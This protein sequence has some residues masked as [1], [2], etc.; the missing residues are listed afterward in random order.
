MITGADLEPGSLSP[1]L[2]ALAW[3]LLHFLWQGALVALV[4][5]LVLAG[6]RNARAELR[7]TVSV[8]A[9]GVMAV[10]PPLTFL[11]VL[12]ALRRELPADPALVLAALSEHV[13]LPGAG[14]APWLLA[15]WCLGA[16]V[17]ALRLAGGFS[18]VHL[19]L[20]RQLV[21]LGEEWEQRVATL[22]RRLGVTRRV[23]IA[24]TREAQGP[25][26]IGWLRPT[27]LFPLSLATRLPQDALE[28]LL[29]HELAH[30]RRHD[31]LVN[32]MQC[33]VE[34]LLFYHPVVWWI[35]RRV[36]VLREYCCDDMAAAHA[37]SALDYA[38]ALTAV[39]E[40]RHRDL[41]YAQHAGAGSLRRR[42]LR[43]IT[44]EGRAGDG[45]WRSAALLLLLALG[46]ALGG[47]SFMHRA[48]TEEALGIAWLP[49]SIQALAPELRQ[50]AEAHG[51]DPELLA[52][53]TLVESAGQP[54]AKSSRGALGLM[55]VMPE[56]GR[57]IAAERGIAG[58][59]PEGLLDPR[60]NLDFGAW[61]LARQLAAFPAPREEERVA[62]AVAAY[63]GGPTVL[64]AHLVEGQEL[65]AETQRYRELLT[66][67]WRER[68]D[69]RSPALEEFLSR[70]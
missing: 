23:T 16:L 27:I 61:Y 18:Y 21:P 40:V 44:R 53:V 29:L 64:R 38:R 46:A 66:A 22:A 45:A 31:A 58:F 65:P 26:V 5:A 6:L 42:V 49:R 47:A 60:V 63:N 34:V 56:T 28:A 8:G 14:A 2:Q 1:M 55:Q 9:V 54:A 69:E 7:Y 13:A 33:V 12:D 50:A 68:E 20:R 37:G 19:V 4:L 41:A 59:T 51:V 43:L 24:G 30:V 39:A 57:A 35:S 3:A 10:L 70:F 48:H 25:L 15:A 36:R 67:M 52:L 11:V 17:M 32:L 62:R